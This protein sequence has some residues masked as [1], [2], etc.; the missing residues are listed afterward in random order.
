[1]RAAL[2]SDAM[3][4]GPQVLLGELAVLDGE[5]GDLAVL[6]RAP[7]AD[8]PRIGV[9]KRLRV[10][11]LD[12]AL[13]RAH[14]QAD[15]AWTGAAE[16]KISV[17]ARTVDGGE[18]GREALAALRSLPDAAGLKLELAATPPLEVP[19]RAVSLRARPVAMAEL[20]PHTP[21]WVDVLVDGQVYRSAR[22]TVEVADERRVLVAR[23]GMAAGEDAASSRFEAV[24]RNVAGMRS[25][26]LA[27][28][29]LPAGARLARQLRAGEILGRESLLA[30]GGV[31]A[32][33]RVRVVARDAQMVIE[34]EGTVIHGGRPG[35]AVEVRVAHSDRALTGVLGAGATVVLR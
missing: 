6:A 30:P 16:V 18:L 10:A 14:R 26:P 22:V 1:V 11:D 4:A 13:R 19:A 12:V 17:A 33:D 15:L 3:V 28:D 2:R 35:Q 31:F 34:V 21:V 32:G 20:A 9:V 7:V 24:T 8:A 29:A 5:A 27:P 25:A 23:T